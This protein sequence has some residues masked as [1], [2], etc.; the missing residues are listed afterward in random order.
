MVVSLYVRIQ[1]CGFFLPIEG[2]VEKF[3]ARSFIPDRKSIKLMTRAVQLGVAAAGVALKEGEMWERVLPN[4]RGIF[5]SSSPC[6]DDHFDLQSA[7]D[8]SYEEGKFSLERF[9][10]KGFS[11]IHPL[12]LVRGLSNNILGFTSAMWDL[13][14]ENM[15]YCQG[16]VGGFHAFVQAARAIEERRVACALVGGAD[17]MTGAEAV[18]G[19][20]CAE[21]SMFF[22]LV[23]SD[24]PL[25]ID[26]D[27]VSQIEEDLPMLGSVGWLIAFY[28][29]WRSLSS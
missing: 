11:L 12:W 2:K 27:R 8:V 25:K 14:G 28:H 29:Y 15:N 16:S 7:L 3:R 19:R 13:Q 20:A 5:V 1:S 4:R 10:T 18:V 6:V 9:A 24:E 21:G 22:L 26:L 23:P 17:V